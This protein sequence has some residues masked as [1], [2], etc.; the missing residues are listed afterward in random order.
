MARAIS[1]QT[2]TAVLVFWLA[3]SAARG[4]DAK[5]TFIIQ[6]IYEEDAHIADVRST[7]GCTSAKFPG[8][9]LKTWEKA[10]IVAVV[11]TRAFERKKD[12]PSEQVS[13]RLCRGN[14]LFVWK[15]KT[16]G[17]VTALLYLYYEQVYQTRQLGAFVLPVHFPHPTAGLVEPDGE[18]FRF[19]FVR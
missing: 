9:I 14:L 10:E 16:F 8:E 11:D 1:L 3:A 6:N 18:R 15:N 12:F 4:S 5:H 7:C 17:I 13:R 2:A 19:N